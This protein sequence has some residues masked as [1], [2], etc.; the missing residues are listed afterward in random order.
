MNFGAGVDS[1][2][3][4]EFTGWITLGKATC[5]FSF[6][7]EDGYTAKL[8]VRTGRQKFGAETVIGGPGYSCARNMPRQIP[9][10]QPK[11]TGRQ[12]SSEA[13]PILSWHD[14]H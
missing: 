5:I 1:V 3:F 6:I 8:Y 9:P 10:S 12:S 11:Q 7:N 2:R 14:E 4:S 13:V